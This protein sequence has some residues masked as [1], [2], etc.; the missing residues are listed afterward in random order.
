MLTL[1][2]WKHACISIAVTVYLSGSDK[3][4]LKSEFSRSLIFVSFMKIFS[5]FHFHYKL[6]Y[7]KLGTHFLNVAH[8]SQN[9]RI[10]TKH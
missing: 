6:V 2:C 7:V 1:Y 4:E 5:T 8:S 10:L 3:F 9:M